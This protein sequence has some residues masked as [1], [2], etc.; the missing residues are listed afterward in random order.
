M[1]EGLLDYQGAAEYLGTTPRHVKE[2]WAQRRLTAVK[3]GR[4]VRFRRCDLDDYV[5]R[6]L[7]KA[8]RA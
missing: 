3:V 1:P 4:R 2:L 7:V 6:N 5:E 8:R